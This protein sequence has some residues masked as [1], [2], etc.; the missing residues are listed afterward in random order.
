MLFLI[1]DVVNQSL[2]FFGRI[3]KSAIAILSAYEVREDA[4]F[5]DELRRRKLE[6]FYQ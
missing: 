4:T 5:F 1:P 6:V 3:G 2:F